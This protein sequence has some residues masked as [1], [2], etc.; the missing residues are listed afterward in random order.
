MVAFRDREKSVQHSLHLAVDLQG[1][2]ARAPLQ[3]ALDHQTTIEA[4]T[5]RLG[6]KMHAV[7]HQVE[8]LAAADARATSQDRG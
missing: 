6:V 1:T 4:L 3:A 2:L 8:H 7:L 5:D